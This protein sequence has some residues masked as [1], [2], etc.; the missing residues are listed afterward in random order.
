MNSFATVSLAHHGMEL[1]CPAADLSED[2]PLATD[3][4]QRLQGWAKRY[5]EAAG[6]NDHH[7]N[8]LEL[9]QQMHDWLNGP[10]SFLTRALDVASA[11]LLIEFAVSRQNCE[12]E[13]A[14]AFI[15]A[16]WELLASDGQFWALRPDLAFCPIRCIGKATEPPEPSANRL[17]LVFMAAAPR[18]ADNLSHEAEEASIL[19]ATRNLGLDLAV[20]ESGTLDLLS[21]CVARERPDVIQV[22]CHGRLPPARSAAGGRHRRRPFRRG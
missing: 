16:P 11:P 10:S 4:C 5:L 7:D 19:T 12:S 2:R 20:E 17:G 8:F 9:G 1:R 21:A 3:D 15:N 13:I 18:G 14:Q 6:K 22:S